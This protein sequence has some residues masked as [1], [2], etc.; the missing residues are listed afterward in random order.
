MTTLFGRVTYLNTMEIGRMD[1]F[2]AS[3]KPFP[4]S[5]CSFPRQPKNAL[6]RVFRGYRGRVFAQRWALKRVE[7]DALKFVLN[8][9]AVN[10]QRAYRG[11]LGRVEASEASF[12]VVFPC[13]ALEASEEIEIKVAKGW[14]V[15][16]LLFG[17]FNYRGGSVFDVDGNIIPGRRVLGEKTEICQCQDFPRFE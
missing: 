1:Q 15:C 2:C 11:Y 8:E 12:R 6:Q 13:C 3:Q 14:S 16:M 5:A 17:M 7:V 10:V 4:L 9:A